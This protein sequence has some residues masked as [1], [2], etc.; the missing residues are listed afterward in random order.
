MGH[1]MLELALMHSKSWPF[2]L[3][4]QI[5]FKPSKAQEKDYKEW[6]SKGFIIQLFQEMK[7]NLFL[8]ENHLN[9]QSTILSKIKLRLGRSVLNIVSLR[10]FHKHHITTPQMTSKII[11]FF[12]FFFFFP[13][14]LFKEIT[15]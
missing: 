13:L 9:E 7:D 11:I 12:F 8:I 4:R 10:K 15:A 3:E 5:L 1:D 6:S 2:F 14:I